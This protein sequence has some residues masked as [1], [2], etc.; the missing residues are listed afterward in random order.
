MQKTLTDVLTTIVDLRKKIDNL[1][2][3]MSDE[4]WDEMP[5]NEKLTAYKVQAQRKSKLIEIMVKVEASDCMV[6]I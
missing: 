4:Y 3:I 1:E 5:E 2:L 6:E